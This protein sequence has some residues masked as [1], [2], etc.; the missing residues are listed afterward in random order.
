MWNKEESGR[1]TWH[2]NKFITVPWGTPA[3]SQWKFDLWTLTAT[4]VGQ[5]DEKL[6]IK[7]RNW[8]ESLYKWGLC[9]ISFNI[10]EILTQQ[11]TIPSGV[12]EISA[13]GVIFWSLDSSLV[14]VNQCFSM[15]MM[16]F[17]IDFSIP[18]VWFK[19]CFFAK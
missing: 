17:N 16:K 14:F 9:H 10:S 6:L 13:S 2:S 19:I 4:V 18:L 8:R 12:L 5:Y 11:H 3:V 1:V 7:D 15:N